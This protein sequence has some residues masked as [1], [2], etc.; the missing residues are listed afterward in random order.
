MKKRS[1]GLRSA[2]GFFWVFAALVLFLGLCAAAGQ[3]QETSE[4]APR[5]MVISL[6]GTVN[7]GSADFFKTSIKQAVAGDFDAFLIEL[8]TPGGLVDSTRDIV[9]DFLA[10]DVPIIVYVTPPGARAGSAGV[11]I[12]MAA[13]VAAMAPGTNI[14]AAHPVA[15]GGQ[16]IDEEM[17]KKITNDTVAW[18]EGIAE[19]RGRNRK[20]AVK[21][22]RDSVSVTATDAKK[23]GVIDFVADDLQDV[24]NKADGR[25][26]E[27][28]AKKKVKVRT[29]GA[30]VTRV[31][32]GLKHRL[33]MRLADPNLAYIFMIVGFLGIYAEF[34]HPGMVFPGVIGAICFLLF[35][36]ST[37]ILPI[38]IVGIMLIVIAL[39]LFVA[40]I[41]FTSYGMM[42]LGGAVCMAMGSVFLFDVPEEV[43][44]PN[45]S[46]AVSWTV[47]LPATI[48]FT[49][50]A[51]LIAF[52]VVRVHR[53][54]IQT[55]RESMVGEIGVASSEI[56]QYTGKV[57]LQGIYWNAVS[58]G[59]IPTGT[60]VKV[61][62][63]SG[64]T[65]TVVPLE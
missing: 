42:T 21:A 3:A 29:A 13:H 31:E 14:G 2:A 37:Q 32:P 44:D 46:F 4:D 7:P 47:V 8:D 60:R 45:F 52:L 19:K 34:S 41:K 53:R 36:M 54:R 20:W 58:D 43:L 64:S 61:T 56:G 18:V 65:F 26:V 40:E 62:R 10:A 9:K 12:T 49:L 48:G 63:V 1:P 16:E 55:G 39:G 59:V 33:I 5:V 25:E 27:L 24:L 15:G 35:L 38:N 51:G 30:V 57:K 23:K 6:Q 11:M 28:G 22:V 50:M 17:S